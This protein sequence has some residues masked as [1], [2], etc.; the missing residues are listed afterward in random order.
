MQTACI[1]AE[2]GHPLAGPRMNRKHHV[3]LIVDLQ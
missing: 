2:I 1:H 3:E